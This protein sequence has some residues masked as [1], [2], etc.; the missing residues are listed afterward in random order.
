MSENLSGK[1]HRFKKNDV[2][3]RENELSRK[4]F[5]LKSGK[6][7]VFKSYMGQ[8]ITLAILGEGE[9][10]GEMSFF[11]GQ[12]RSA[13]VEALTPVECFV[14]DSEE[15]QLH[16]K[17]LP[18]WFQP[19]FKTVFNRL[20]TADM[21]TT[22]LQSMNEVEKR[23]F[24]RD[25][26]A[27]RIYAEL[28][29]FNKIL[30]L[31]YE[32]ARGATGMEARSET[33]LHDL[34]E[35]LGER[36]LSLQ[37][38]WKLLKEYD[39]IDRDAESERGVV[40]VRKENLEKWTGELNEEIES[41]RYTFLSHTAVA[42]LKRVVSHVQSCEDSFKGSPKVRVQHDSI[43]LNHMPLAEEAMVELEKL[44]LIERQ[45]NQSFWVDMP[46]VFK[47]Y[48]YQSFLKYFDHTIH[49]S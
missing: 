5:V 32:R 21:R 35:L 19:I 2:L 38:Y 8:K 15:A 40:I 49:Q 23:H 43:D 16:F 47:A 42:I 12:P 33:L 4:M 13:T 48:T 22:M 18:D 41:G 11:D 25:S 28:L 44:N 10:F 20:R 24:K 46:K 27:Q 30:V 14:V 34:D 36:T 45:G 3:I 29:R 7:R 37:S 17:G 39:F 26:V 31:V 9:I 6:V 1:I